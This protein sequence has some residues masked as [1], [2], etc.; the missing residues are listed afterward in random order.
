[1]K[2][3]FLKSCEFNSYIILN[4]LQKKIYKNGGFI[5]ST[6]E[7]KK[8][9]IKIYNRTLLNNIDNLKET[10][11]TITNNLNNNTY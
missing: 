8:E 6:W 9:K 10:I 5:V 7:T 2:K 1:M 3:L 4:E 11:Q